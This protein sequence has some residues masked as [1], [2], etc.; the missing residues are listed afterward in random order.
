MKNNITVSI[1]VPVYNAEPYLVKCLDSV[2]NQTLDNVEIII[3]DDGS[4]DG[5]SEICQEYAAKDSR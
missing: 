5:S 2:V 3:I 4:T 1:V